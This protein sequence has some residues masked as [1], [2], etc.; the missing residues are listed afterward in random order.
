M[1]ESPDNVMK[2]LTLDDGR[3]VLFDEGAATLLAKYE[4]IV[5]PDEW[6]AELWRTRNGN[7]LLRTCSYGP[8]VSTMGAEEIGPFAVGEVLRRQFSWEHLTP[9]GEEYWDQIQEI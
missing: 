9:E 2:A 6:G 4:V 3:T 1:T 5:L 8:K 7:F